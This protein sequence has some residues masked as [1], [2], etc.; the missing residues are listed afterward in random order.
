MLSGD[1]YGCR[2]SALGGILSSAPVPAMGGHPA[3]SQWGE[4]RKAKRT[5]E[6]KKDRYRKLMLGRG[7]ASSLGDFQHTVY[8]KFLSTSKLVRNFFQDLPSLTL[9]QLAAAA[10]FRL[11]Q[12]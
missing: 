4:D 11:H 9:R 12:R 8:G 3:L 6:R 1:P 5:E 7:I 10:L 2:D